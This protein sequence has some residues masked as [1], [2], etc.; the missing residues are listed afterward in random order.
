M[1][2]PPKRT[3]TTTQ[4]TPLI[5][6]FPYSPC[7]STI[8]NLWTHIIF[9]PN[10]WSA[11][12]EHRPLQ[13]RN[14]DTC[15]TVHRSVLNNL[16]SLSTSWFLGTLDRALFDLGAGLVVPYCIPFLYT[17]RYPRNATR[18]DGGRQT[19]YLSCEKID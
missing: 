10:Q 19:L 12:P 3:R 17:I 1:G 2:D 4:E 18:T 7:E 5:N 13:Y 14:S 9:S 6:Q 16:V 8:F 15:K 11:L